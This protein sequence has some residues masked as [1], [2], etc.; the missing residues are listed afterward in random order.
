MRFWI[1]IACFSLLGMNL[2][3][4]CDPGGGTGG[5]GADVIVGPPEVRTRE[6]ST[7]RP[8]NENGGANSRGETLS[9]K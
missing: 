6:A 3:A 7:Y 9:T 8:F 2:H 5:T 4:Q 1:F